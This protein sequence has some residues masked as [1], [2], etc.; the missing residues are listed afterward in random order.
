VC[1]G[2]AYDI[3]V[4]CNTRS[5]DAVETIATYPDL[6]SAQLAQSLLDAEGIDSTIPE[7][8]IAG[9][10]W[11]WSTALQGI[12]L[13]VA[14]EDAEPAKALLSTPTDLNIAE[15]ATESG[16][17]DA[18]PEERCP[19][20]GADLKGGWTMAPTRQSV[21]DVSSP[22]DTALATHRNLWTF[23]RMH[24]VWPSLEENG[25]RQMRRRDT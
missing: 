13:Q 5:G 17:L 24:Q 18:A 10:D 22:T 11:Q 8:N 3:A 15:A 20:C 6:I 23:V 1:R 21:N 14:A 9:I 19:F 4:T 25:R 12:R 7:E 16:S 2:W